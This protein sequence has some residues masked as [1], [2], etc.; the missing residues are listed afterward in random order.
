MRVPGLLD[1]FRQA[2]G[3]EGP[4][5]ALAKRTVLPLKAM[6]GPTPP[7]DERPSA[8]RACRGFGLLNEAKC[9]ARPVADPTV[10]SS[11]PQSRL[12]PGTIA[13]YPV[14][15]ET[16]LG[17]PPPRV[18]S[19]GFAK[20]KVSRE[21]SAHWCRITDQFSE[22][23]EPHMDRSDYTPYQRLDKRAVSRET[24]GQR[25]RRWNQSVPKGG[26]SRADIRPTGRSH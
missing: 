5:A 19:S 4:R 6:C 23:W 13:A 12:Y 24:A 17:P 15:P 20:D 8:L 7:M 9:G 18:S 16:P 26:P 14:P 11:S 3:R 10:S 2:P 22:S 21:T 1:R 25:C